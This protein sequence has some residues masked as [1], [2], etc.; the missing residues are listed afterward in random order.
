MKRREF[1]RTAANA[2][3]S[4]A[5]LAA[6]APH[7]LRDASAKEAPASARARSAAKPAADGEPIRRTQ[8]AE[9]SDAYRRAQQAG[10]PLLVI[11]IPDPIW[12]KD[13]YGEYFGTW[14]NEGSVEQCWPLSLCELI[15]ARMD[16][17]RQIVPTVG[18]GHP[19][20]V[21]VETDQVPATIQRLD[22]PLPPSIVGTIG[23]LGIEHMQR[24]I[25]K[26]RY[27]YAASLAKQAADAVAGSPALLEK[28]ANQ[29]RATLPPSATQVDLRAATLSVA[30]ADALAPLVALAASHLGPEERT[31]Q[32]K[33]LAAAA[34]ARVRD[35]RIPGSHWVRHDTCGRV[36]EGFE[37]NA[38]PGCA[39]AVLRKKTPRYL[40][41]RSVD[42]AGR[43][44]DSER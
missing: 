15:C 40:L 29:V 23:V 13:Y 42:S 26:Q 8:L 4:L 39:E 14:L 43:I 36:V 38:A 41:L 28:R 35:Q 20:M 22:K 32:H 17:L 1:F 3:A 5:L 6:A 37:H 33:I 24:Q 9:I 44:D 25:A 2:G 21:L 19:L 12:K 18:A 34:S 30:Q 27:L 31:A 10:K 11:V 7:S 16:D